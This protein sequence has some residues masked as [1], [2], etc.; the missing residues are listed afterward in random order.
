MP[1]T[2]PTATAVARHLYDALSGT[3]AAALLEL[4]TDD[5]EGL[6][7]AGMPHGVG[8]AHHG[9][10]DMLGVWGTIDTVYD[11]S[12]VPSEF[13]SV[14]EDRVVVVGRYQGSARDGNT[15]VDATFAHVITTRGDRVASLQQITDTASWAI[16]PAT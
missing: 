10:N 11:V 8:G 12:V 3:D 1:D 16:A 13:L 2:T 4:L 6:V 14:S 9:P 5:F 7:S 15:A